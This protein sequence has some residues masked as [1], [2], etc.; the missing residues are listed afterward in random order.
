MTTCKRLHGWIQSAVLI[1]AF[2]V[3]RSALACEPDYCTDDSR[4][5]DALSAKK[6]HLL[7]DGFPMRLIQLLDI[8]NQCIARINLEQDGFTVIDVQDEQNK[9]L[10]AWTEDEERIAKRNVSEGKSLR[11]WIVNQ[12][13]AFQCDGDP[14]FNQRTD[15]N[16]ADDVNADGAIECLPVRGD[17]TCTK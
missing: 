13:Q 5:P 8:G 10:I 4:I 6:Q 14:P 17:V 16:A 2:A 1:T 12:R 9:L 11:Y 15:Y 3:G 7:N